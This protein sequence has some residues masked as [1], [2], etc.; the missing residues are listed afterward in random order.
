MHGQKYPAWL[1]PAGLVGAIFGAFAWLQVTAVKPYAPQAFG[2]GIL[3]FFL[4]KWF[5]SKKGFKNILPNPYSLEIIPLTFAL[6]LLVGFSGGAESA[7]F[8][9]AYVLLLLLV[10]STGFYTTVIATAA[11]MLFIYGTSKLG[12]TTYW[13][14]LLSTPLMVAFFMYA[15]QQLQVTRTQA[16][17]LQDEKARRETAEEQSAKLANFIRDFLSPKLR[18]LINL[19][20]QSDTPKATILN[21]IDLLLSEATK[22]EQKLSSGTQEKPPPS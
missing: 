19:G 12:T 21:Q 5:V 3:V 17:S 16:A 8:P 10:L 4:L 9:I 1:I 13:Q 11:I 15:E 14:A 2:L 22:I 20:N 7:Y 18:A 6:L